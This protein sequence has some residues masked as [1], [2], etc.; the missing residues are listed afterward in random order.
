MKP[1][2]LKIK[3]DRVSNKYGYHLILTKYVFYV[4]NSTKIMSGIRGDL[5]T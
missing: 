4:K 5:T 1:P 2:L 3:G